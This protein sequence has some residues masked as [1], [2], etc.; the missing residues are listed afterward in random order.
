MFADLFNV[1]ECNVLQGDMSSPGIDNC[2][3]Q[4]SATHHTRY[5]AIHFSI[6]RHQ[7]T[8]CYTCFQLPLKENRN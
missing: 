3:Y 8:L 6:K 1:A 4:Y 7:G 2:K 5:A